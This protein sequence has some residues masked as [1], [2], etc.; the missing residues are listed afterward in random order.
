[1]LLSITSRAFHAGSMGVMCGLLHA[2]GPDHVATLVSFSS[3]LTPWAACK[4]GAAWGLGHC[5][6]IFGIALL[7]YLIGSLPGVHVESW[8]KNGDYIIGASMI[9]VASYFFVRESEFLTVDPDGN[10]T[11][12]GCSCSHSSIYS[13]AGSACS[14]SASSPV[15]QEALNGSSETTP[16]VPHCHDSHVPHDSDLQGRGAKGAVVGFVQGMCCPMGLVQ[17]SYL[18]G[19]GA[20]DSIVFSLVTVVVAV[21]GTSLLAASWAGLTRSNLLKS[22]NPFYMYRMSCGFTFTL[23]VLWIVANYCNVLDKLNYAEAT[24]E[25]SNQ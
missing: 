25:L 5:A 6:G 10:I 3:L 1:M 2:I 14:T 17:L 12:T 24:D 16:L 22:V 18:A 19:R 20:L 9:L 15:D 11:A 23:G 8:E 7:T 13:A 21:T 4:V